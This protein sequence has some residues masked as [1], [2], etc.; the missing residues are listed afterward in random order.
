[1]E[2]LE[3]ESRLLGVYPI[4]LRSSE[5]GEGD[6]PLSHKEYKSKSRSLQLV[7]GLRTRHM[8]WM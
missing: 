6:S 1:M 3:C 5:R 2:K 8:G 7:Q 4:Y